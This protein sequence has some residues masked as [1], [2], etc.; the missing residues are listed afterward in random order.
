MFLHYGIQPKAW[1]RI[2]AWLIHIVSIVG[3]WSHSINQSIFRRLI[4]QSH[5]L[6]TLLQMIAPIPSI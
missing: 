3:V 6:N 2:Y 5:L 1:H 4:N